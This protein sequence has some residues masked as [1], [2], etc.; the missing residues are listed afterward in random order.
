MIQFY[1]KVLSVIWYTSIDQIASLT[2]VVLGI[3]WLM[4][5]QLPYVD[6]KSRGAETVINECG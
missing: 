3:N 1:I 5:D 6:L 2:L 4:L